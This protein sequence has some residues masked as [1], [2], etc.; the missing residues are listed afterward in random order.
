MQQYL[1]I[2]KISSGVSPGISSCFRNTKSVN[3]FLIFLRQTHTFLQIIIIIIIFFGIFSN[4]IKGRNGELTSV[5]HSPPGSFA[6]TT[7]LKVHTI[8]WESSRV[9]PTAERK[10]QH[11]SDVV[12]TV[13]EGS[14]GSGSWSTGSPLCAA[15]V[16]V[17]CV[18]FRG[19]W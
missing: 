15:P 13:L 6:L 12:L 18:E 19:C 16:N 3:T 17:T 5:N 10:R 2:T 4:F 14:N 7:S 9:S 8:P 11:L 1:S